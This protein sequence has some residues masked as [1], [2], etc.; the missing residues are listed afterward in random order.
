M[1]L[2]GRCALVT[3][4]GSGLGRATA[5]ALHAAGANV[6]ML[7]VDANRLAAAVEELGKGACPAVADVRRPDEIESALD[8]ARRTFG[9]LQIAVSCAGVPSSAKILSNG[10]PHELALWTRVI[11]IN[12]TGTFNVMR[13]AA[14]RMAA[15]ELDPESDERGVIINTASIAAFDGQKGQAAYAA[16]KAGV[17]G[18]TLPVARD[19]AARSIRC[20]AV[21]PGLFETEIFQHIGDKGVDALKRSLLFPERMGRP[22][23]FAA[24]VRHIIENPYLNGSCLRL[25]GAARLP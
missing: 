4:A 22:E 19:L 12:L 25:D 16:S 1:H 23:E 24:F 13:L 5:R 10:V 2:K 9:S 11:E 14:A 15:N 17:A 3:G 20:V 7:D 6:V 21:A 8:L 18:M